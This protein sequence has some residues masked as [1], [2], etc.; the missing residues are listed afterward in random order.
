MRDLDFY[1]K[2]L[3]EY[4]ILYIDKIIS[5]KE[6]LYHIKPID[7]AIEKIQMSILRRN[8]VLKVSS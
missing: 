5:E 1:H 8:L 4:Y 2:A 6:Y 7:K 3:E